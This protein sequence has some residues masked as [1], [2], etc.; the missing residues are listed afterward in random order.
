MRSLSTTNA[1][2]FLSRTLNSPK[3]PETLLARHSTTRSHPSALPLASRQTNP[4]SS[5]R[6][7]GGT[8]GRV[9]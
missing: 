3:T 6:R 4:H 2:P 1:A 5:L 8:R 9:S 7:T